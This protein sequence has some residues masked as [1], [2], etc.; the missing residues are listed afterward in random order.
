MRKELGLITNR[1]SISHVG[2]M[3]KCVCWIPKGLPQGPPPCGMVF[4]VRY[5][6]ELPSRMPCPRQGVAD[7]LQEVTSSKDQAQY[8]CHDKP[9]RFVSVAEMAE[10]FQRTQ[11]AQRTRGVLEMPY[12]RA[13]CPEGAPHPLH[14]SLSI[15]VTPPELLCLVLVFL[16]IALAALSWSELLIIAQATRLAMSEIGS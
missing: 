2:F 4:P 9:Y 11:T 15:F 6:A 12:D 5:R 10:A 8:W 13:A 14:P 16:V 1:T 7:F 3:Y